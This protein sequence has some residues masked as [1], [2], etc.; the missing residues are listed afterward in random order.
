MPWSPTPW[1][2]LGRAQLGAGLPR[3][4]RAS[5]HKAISI[6]DGDWE[7][8]YLLASASSGKARR[9]AL[10][11]AARLYPR[12]QLLRTKAGAGAAP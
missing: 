11:Q 12:A 8:W 7:L 10:E 9:V 4:A 1:V 5:F 2:A 3:D 6:D